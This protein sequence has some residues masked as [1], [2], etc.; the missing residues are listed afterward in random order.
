MVVEPGAEVVPPL[1]PPLVASPVVGVP[2]VSV[3]GAP[4]DPP[5]DEPAPDAPPD[6]PSGSNPALV[7]PDGS[8]H[9]TST[10]TDSDASNGRRR[11]RMVPP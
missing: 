2:V 8:P 1:D 9:E 4:V 10:T 3:V 7:D 11:L 6:D 5:L